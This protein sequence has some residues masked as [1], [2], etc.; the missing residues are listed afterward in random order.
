VNSHASAWGAGLLVLSAWILAFSL[1]AHLTSSPT[2]SNTASGVAD[3]LLGESRQALSLNL[4]SEADL[5]FHKGVAHRDASVPIPGPFHRWQTAITPEQHAHAEGGASA[6]ILPWLKLATQADPHNVEAFL[7][8]SFWANTGLQ[9]LDLA[10]DILN[11]AQRLNPGDYRIPLEKSRL[12]ITSHHF[13][14]ARPL[15]DAALTLHSK[16]PSTPERVRELTL[17]QAEILT[18]LGFLHET[19]GE[20]REAITCFNTVLSLFPDRALIKERIDLLEAGKTPT[21]SA[22][23]LLE[24]ITR[25]TTHDACMDDDDHDHEHEKN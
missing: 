1:A 4:F 24:R 14:A 23:S 8:A 3:L 18:F 7:V 20:I 10:R 6:E 22:Q 21:D 12:A 11:T 2:S 19:K 9:R 16:T 15:L 17:D 13:N 5:Y 25:R